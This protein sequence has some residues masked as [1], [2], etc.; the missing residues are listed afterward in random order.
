M[1]E[2]V[3]LVLALQE[4]FSAFFHLMRCKELPRAQLFTDFDSF[5]SLLLISKQSS[6]INSLTCSGSKRQERQEAK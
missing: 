3:M 5:L 1:E 4:T 2:P 6:L